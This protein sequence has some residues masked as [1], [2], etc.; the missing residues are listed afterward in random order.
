VTPDL[1]ERREAGIPRSSERGP[2]GPARWAES[3]N[4][5]LRSRSPEETRAAGRA[6][7][8]VLEPGDVVL[9]DG[10]LGAGK[11]V[12]A[13]GIAEG[14]D[15]DETVVSP[16][17]TLARE[18]EGRHR[19]VHVDVY[20]LDHV[21]EFLE[22]GL[23]DLAGDDA[24]TVVEWGEAVVAELPVDHLQVRLALASD[25]EDQERNLTLRFAGPDWYR[26]ADDVRVS[27]SGAG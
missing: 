25:A 16:T 24:V 12:F 19:L 2:S 20:R 17:F 6:L 5:V 4:L 10:E 27:L 23:E 13:K 9:L 3:G 26:R 18:Y 15:V 21:Q 8:A 11:T 1:S 7:G 22:L 14:L